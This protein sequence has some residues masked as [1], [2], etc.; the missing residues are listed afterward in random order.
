MKK[1]TIVIAFF[2][3]AALA[4][5]CV[6]LLEPGVKASRGKYSLDLSVRCQDPATKATIEGVES[7]HENTL[8]RVDWFIFK[9]TSDNA[10]AVLDGITS[11]EDISVTEPTLVASVDMEDYID[12]STKTFTGYVFLLANLPASNTHASLAALTLGE[13]KQLQVSTTLDLL[14]T[15]GKFKAQDNFV[16][17]SSTAPLPSFSLS[18]N[19]TTANV[20]APLSRVAAKITLD[21]SIVSA[22]DEIKAQMSG[23]DTLAE[24]YL[25]TWYPDVNNIQVYL[26]YANQH[27]TIDRTL[28][29]TEP[30]SYQDAYFFTYNR[31]G[32]KSTATKNDDN[33]WNVTGTPFYS[34]PMKWTNSD[35]H[36]PFIK[37]ILPWR[38][39]VEDPTYNA[40]YKY[41]TH[42]GQ[43]GTHV[44][45]KLVSASRDHIDDTSAATQ[46]FFYKINLPLEDNTLS[47]NTWYKIALDVAI[48][49]GRTDDV[50]M[51]LAGKY[52]VVDWNSP[53]FQAG[54][55]LTQGSYL[56]LATPRDTF[57]IYGSSSI[58]IPVK[59]SHDLEVVNPT[60]SYYN[61]R[62]A[63]P[64]TGSLNYS[65]TSSSGANYT[66]TP[67]G[68]SSVTL[69]HDVVSNLNNVTSSDISTITYKFRIR[70]ANN[71][72]SL[73]KDITVIQYPSIYIES[74]T[75]GD[76][77]VNG[78][79]QGNNDL[80]YPY[81]YLSYDN[82]T[83]TIYHV[84][85]SAFNGE[86]KYYTPIRRNSPDIQYEYI[87]TDPRENAGW[88]SRD[89]AAYGPSNNTTAWPSETVQ[90]MM[91]GSP[92]PNYIA[93]SFLVSSRYGRPGNSSSDLTFE[94]AQKRC[95][96]YQEAGYP[97]G[98]WR[99]PTEA[100]VYFLFT[101]QTRRLITDLYTTGNNTYGYWASSGYV[102]GR[103]WT[104]GTPDFRTL[105]NGE[106]AS[107]RCVYDTWFWGEEPDSRDTYHPGPTF[108]N[109]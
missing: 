14:G 48:L 91:V 65:T 60:S 53:T 100:E 34:Y 6:E 56:S 17:A 106:A 27:T 79:G 81:G 97:A 102:F 22:I 24:E 51:E 37:I 19:S 99:L 50:S 8:T 54:G 86:S 67:D 103:N 47:S 66:I 72:S 16:M 92:T 40:N 76:A 87:I 43:G 11:Y 45:N 90:N 74:L 83:T 105:N 95:A 89:I 104:T 58:E 63:T 41:I 18:E 25:Q 49:G 80:P 52:Y 69:T 23:R 1:N 108:Y 35:A 62:T 5:A 29:G 30:F 26:T 32:F 10:T 46:E 7:L 42:D 70:H 93:P 96:T 88:S 59:S 109:N 39:Y 20:L 3:I 57:Y 73:Y 98:R 36:A 28:Y 2:L 68:R 38:P 44:G 84:H 94:V 33:S 12:P 85:V 61:Y 4:A 77:Y 31:Y 64:T 15:D 13:L 107:I 101:L 21:I 9:S 55:E 78:K 71:A 82:Q 75:P